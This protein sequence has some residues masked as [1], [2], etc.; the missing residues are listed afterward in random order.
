MGVDAALAATGIGIIKTV[1]DQVEVLDTELVRTSGKQKLARRIDKLYRSLCIKI[2]TYKPNILA[3][4][5]IF[6][7]KNIRIALNLGQARGMAIL[8]SA[9]YDID[10]YEF[11]AK[12]I[13]MAVTGNGA[14]SKQQVAFMV[15]TLLN[16]EAEFETY[17][18]SDSLAVAMCAASR[19]NLEVYQ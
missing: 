19:I 5:D 17:D 10:L 7:S 2:E 13:K 9:Q 12:E 8:A 4:E 15:R 3:L 1:D 18:I 16:L 6:Y 14:A 11:S